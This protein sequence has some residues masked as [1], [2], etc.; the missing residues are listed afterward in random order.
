MSPMN[1]QQ[2]QVCREG[3]PLRA[4]SVRHSRLGLLALALATVGTTAVA[5]ERSVTIAHNTPTL[6]ERA[7]WLGPS[8]PTAAIEVTIW[9]NLHDRAGMDALAASLYRPGSPNYQRWLSRDQIAKRFGPTAEE[10]RTVARFFEANNL[11]VVSVA[12]GNFFVRARG[13]VADI[14]RA[15]NVSLQDYRLD[16]R[17]VRSNDRDPTVVGM[18]APL[19]RA[20]SGL[21]NTGY[22]HPLIVRPSGSALRTG[23]VVPTPRTAPD[24]YSSSCFDVENQTFS[25]NNSGDLPVGHY[26]GNHIKLE[27]LASAGCGYGPDAIKTAYDLTPLYAEHFTGKGQTIVIIDWCGS[28]TIQSDANAFSSRYGL[29]KLT[30]SNF[31]IIYTPAP[32]S[33]ISENQGEINLD[34]EWAHALAPGASIDLVVPPSAEFQDVDE[35]VFYAVNYGLG[36][37][38]SGSYGSMESETP[39]SVLDTE[40]IIAEMAAISGISTNF[41]SGDYGDFSTYGNVTVNAPA[42]SPWATGVGGTSLALKANNTIEWQSGWGTTETLLADEGAISDPTVPQYF[43]FGSGGGP[44]NCARQDAKMNCLGGFAKPAFQKSLAGTVRQVPDISWLADPFTGAVIAITIPD[45]SPGLSWEVI[46]GTSLAAPMFSALWAIANEEAGKPLGQA[47]QYLYTL[48][49]GAITDVVPV[50]STSNLTAKVVASGATH[51][52]GAIATVGGTKPATPT[53]FISALWDYGP[54]YATAVAITFGTDCAISTTEFG[55]LCTSPT[56]LS[57]GPGWDNV[58]GLGTPDGKAF[59]DAFRSRSVKPE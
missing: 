44:S 54:G 29:P 27:S 56:A 20:V 35:A 7:D 36:N 22:T 42:D 21:D 4:A 31:K 23:K 1:H 37:S 55:T 38:I 41:S 9:L 11:H 48:P 45:Q 39:A 24:F 3:N 59:A 33:C 43:Q 52:Y 16:G 34:V 53:D 40:N 46:G 5:E 49:K 51:S 18:A 6:V 25:T 17:I 28:A 15:F 30:D 57:T 26:S 12:P 13:A 19:V 8:D 32:S 10:A 14:E 50:S 2:L 58:T 47:A